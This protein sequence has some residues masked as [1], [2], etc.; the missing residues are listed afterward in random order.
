MYYAIHLVLLAGGSGTKLC[1]LSRK[2]YPRQCARITG[3]ESLFQAAAQQ[4]AGPGF[5]APMVI[6]GADF[7]FIV[8]EQMAAVAISPAAILIEPLARNTAPAVCAVAR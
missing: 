8:N 6:T 4:L 3:D 7:R 1:L 5:S 2:S